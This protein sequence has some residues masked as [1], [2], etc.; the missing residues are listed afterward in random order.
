MHKSFKDRM[1]A[2][3]RLERESHPYDRPVEEWSDAE[4]EA[5]LAEAYRHWPRLRTMS[6]ADLEAICAK[7]L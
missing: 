4:L 5:Y 1:V 3:E 7:E 2:L 6:D